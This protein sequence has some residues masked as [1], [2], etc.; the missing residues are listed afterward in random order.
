MTGGASSPPAAPVAPSPVRVWA[1]DEA[2]FGLKT[3]FR[4]RW[5]P[6]GSRAPWVVEDRYEWLWLYA[7]VEPATGASFCLYLPRLDGACL[8][9]F[10]QAFRQAYPDDDIVL[11]LDGSGSHSNGAVTWPVGIHPLRLPPYS[12][13]LNPAERW[14]ADLRGALA[15]TLFE[16]I[17][18][19]MTALTQELK[20]YWAQPTRLAQLTGYP[21]WLE[22][23]ANIRTSI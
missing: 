7:A 17:D 3:W 12:P 20:P 8:E 16:S 15:N 9:V 11:V 4:R 2:R 21:W 23:I 19:L 10:L 1:F 5:C 22:G 13:E 18:A 6:R 14:F